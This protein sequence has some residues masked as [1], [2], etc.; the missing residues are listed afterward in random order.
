M[1]VIGIKDNYN[2]NNNNSQPKVFLMADSSLLKDGK[3]LFLPDFAEKFIAHP[4][5]VVRINRLGKNIAKR[6]ASRYY[7]AVTVGLCVEAQNFRDSNGIAGCDS[8]INAF[9]GAAILGN[10]IPVEDINDL[11][12]C[13]FSV[14][15]GNGETIALNSANLTMSIDSLIEDISKYFTFKIGDILFTGYC[16]DNSFSLSINDIINGTINGNEVLHFKVK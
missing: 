8:A 7:D 2:I 13:S 4:A 15:Y 9:D 3:P 1:K 6:F 5:L 11:N 16:A 12:N 14:N 10:F